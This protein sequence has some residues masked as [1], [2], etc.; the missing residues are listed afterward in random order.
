MSSITVY[1]DI[2]E[3]EVTFKVNF[4]FVPYRRATYL[5]PE[6][7]GYAEFYPPTATHVDGEPIKDKAEQRRLEN[8]YSQDEDKLQQLANDQIESAH[9]WAIDRQIDALLGK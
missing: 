3:H 6:D 7:G 1:Q 5:D 9:D 8:L 4:T 2:D